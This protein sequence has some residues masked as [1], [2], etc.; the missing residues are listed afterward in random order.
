MYFHSL[1][2]FHRN[3]IWKNNVYQ[4]TVSIIIFHVFLRI[5]ALY[6]LQGQTQKG[7]WL[8][9]WKH[10]PWNTGSALGM[11][12]AG[13]SWDYPRREWPGVKTSRSGQCQCSVLGK[14]DQRKP[15]SLQSGIKAGLRVDS[16]PQ[17]SRGCRSPDPL[18]QISCSV[19][20]LVAHSQT[21]RAIELCAIFI[22]FSYQFSLTLLNIIL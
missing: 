14:I 17:S 3:S 21:F 13:C 4:E 15:C 19:F 16:A 11:N 12:S 7:V 10:G 9:S 2:K 18:H 8:G 20:I 5:I 1:E 22:L 6:R